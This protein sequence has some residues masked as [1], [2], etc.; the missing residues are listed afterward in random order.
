MKFEHFGVNV[1][2]AR[3]M[4]QWYVENCG[5]R[6]VRG[7]DTA[8]WAHFLA[9]STGRM[10]MEIYTN[11][12]DAVPDYT[13]QHPLR[14]HVAF[15]VDDPEAHSARL[16]KAGAK[17]LS[18]DRLPDGSVLVM[19]RDPWGVPLQLCRRAKPF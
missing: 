13:A 6:I 16:E 19:M 15:A 9:D 4:A 1:P 14:L 8:P 12:A 11:E 17:A 10:V 18:L 5:M 7:N 3:A 2:D